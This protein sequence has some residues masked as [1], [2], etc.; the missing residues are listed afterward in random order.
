MKDVCELHLSFNDSI[1]NLTTDG[2]A[3]FFHTC[4]KKF[5][6]HESSMHSKYGIVV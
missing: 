6:K 3:P 4:D 1:E 5:S 2:L